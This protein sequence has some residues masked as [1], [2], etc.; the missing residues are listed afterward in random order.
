MTDPPAHTP[1]LTVVGVTGLPEVSAGDDIAALLQPSLAT[2]AW[3]D[4]SQGI[5]DGD[6]VVVTSKVISKAE[7]RDV[8]A[9]HREQAIADETQE[10][11][12]VKHT[13]RGTTYIVRNIHGVV[14]AAAGIDA[15]NAPDGRVLLLPTDP[16]ASARALRSALSSAES[17]R[18]AVLITDTL[19][20]PWREGLTDA[21]IGAAGLNPLDDLRGVAD[22]N[23]VPMEVTVRAIAD[24]VAAAADLVKGKVEGVPVAVV[25]G[26]ASFVTDDDGP[27]AQALVRDP[28]HDLFTLGTAEARALGRDAGQREAV[29]LRRTVRQFTDELVPVEVIDHAVAEAL[30]APA[31]HHTRPWRFVHLHDHGVRT[32][33]LDAMRAA[34]ISDLRELD[35]FDD[36]AIEQRVARGD[37]LR[38][39]PEVVFAFVDVADAHDYPDDRRHTGER[40]LFLAAG[41]AGVQNFMITLAV[42]G[43]GSAWISSTMFCPDTVR[44]SLD[45]PETW[46]PL[47]AI[48]I[49]YPAQQPQARAAMTDLSAYLHR[50]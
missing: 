40:E 7:G 18:I 12:A 35:G 13:P 39:A 17:V 6:I 2:V 14:L 34:W 22:A 44:D 1:T 31:P 36:A 45:L 27:G 20:R 29:G 41:A 9:E 4:G 8:P 26:L 46:V 23:G 47:G 43:V 50:R 37:V 49:G 33:V 38:R 11:I 32:R 25:R 24:E 5:R 3:P 15:S 42:D 30:T 48:A 16:D 21:V 19:G 10:V 28:E